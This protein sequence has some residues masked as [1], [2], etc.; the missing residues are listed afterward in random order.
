MLKRAQRWYRAKVSPRPCRTRTVRHFIPV[1]E[2][3]KAI[4]YW[5]YNLPVAM[6]MPMVHAAIHQAYANILG[7]PSINHTLGHRNMYTSSVVDTY[8][9]QSDYEYVATPEARAAI[10]QVLARLSAIYYSTVH[11]PGAI[12]MYSALSVF[13]EAGW[14]AEWVRGTKY[15]EPRVKTTA[16]PI[17]GICVSWNIYIVGGVEYTTEDIFRDVKTYMA[18]LGADAVTLAKFEISSSLGI[19]RPGVDYDTWLDFI[20]RLAIKNHRGGL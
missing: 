12:E 5:P 8:R 9:R 18:E 19:I 3:L 20:A 7:V 6:K 17:L 14:T 1:A 10:E 16:T 2:L 15:Q 11:K 13:P 4:P